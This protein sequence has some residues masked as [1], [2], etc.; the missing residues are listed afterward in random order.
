MKWKSDNLPI[1]TGEVRKV[2]E[3]KFSGL[4]IPKEYSLTIADVKERI[5]KCELVFKL[6]EELER[7]KLF[8]Y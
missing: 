2:S 4:A 3:G 6:H 7:I 1:E 5:R 8:C